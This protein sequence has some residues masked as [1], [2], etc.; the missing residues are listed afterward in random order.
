M[1][2]IIVMSTFTVV[3]KK[4]VKCRIYEDDYETSIPDFTNNTGRKNRY[5]MM[6]NFNQEHE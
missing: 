2:V 4:D 5:N 3:Q 6:L 1:N